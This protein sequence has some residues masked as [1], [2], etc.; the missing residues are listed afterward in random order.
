M[1]VFMW[2][3]VWALILY[4][5]T[6]Q[7]VP[8]MHSYSILSLVLLSAQC[9]LFLK[10]TKIAES[11]IEE[12]I[13]I[14]MLLKV[15]VHK[16]FISFW[17]FRGKANNSRVKR[18]RF[19]GNNFWLHKSKYYLWLNCCMPLILFYFHILREKQKFIHR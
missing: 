14:Y 5:G 16:T 19:C 17:L 1:Q 9:H 11:I 6:I 18:K 7:T 8:L 15:W 13:L 10:S 3:S 12:W 4:G 2:A